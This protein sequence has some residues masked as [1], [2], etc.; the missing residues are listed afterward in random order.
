MTILAAVLRDLA[1]GKEADALAEAVYIEPNKFKKQHEAVRLV[2]HPEDATFFREAIQMPGATAKAEP[3]EVARTEAQA[4][5]WVNAQALRKRVLDLSDGQREALVEF[6]LGD[7]VL[8]VVSTESRAAALRIFSVLND[9]GLDLSNADV[10]K[11]DLLERFSEPTQLEHYAQQWRAF[12]VDLG[13]SGF[14]ALLDHLRFIRERRKNSRTLSEAYAER[15]KDQPAASKSSWILMIG[16]RPR[17]R[18]ATAAIPPCSAGTG[19]SR[20]QTSPVR[21]DGEA[22]K[23]GLR[24]KELR[25]KRPRKGDGLDPRPHPFN[26]VEPDALKAAFT[27]LAPAQATAFPERVAR[28]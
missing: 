7:C 24:T 19:V 20:R 10:I 27:E 14:E 22:V 12:E 17:S 11:A 6:L 25:A 4:N 15:F 16:R 28:L 26:G 8:V 2:G 3:P 23:P 9:R 1:S 5:M 21:P 13:R 18:R